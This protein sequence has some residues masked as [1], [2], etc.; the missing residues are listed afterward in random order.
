MRTG[1]LFVIQ[2]F[3][4]SF[5]H[6]MIRHEEYLHQKFKNIINNINNLL[7]RALNSSDV[8]CSL[9]K[10]YMTHTNIECISMFLYN[11]KTYIT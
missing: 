10:G 9:W 3:S 2:A 7:K 1:V 6:C 8:P 4:Y 5:M 11:A